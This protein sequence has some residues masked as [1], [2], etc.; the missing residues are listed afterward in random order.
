MSIVVTHGDD[1]ITQ[2]ELEGMAPEGFITGDI[3]LNGPDTD[4][5]RHFI[6][7]WASFATHGF[8]EHFQNVN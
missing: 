3:K 2:F 5:S 7:L 4:F 6:R 8:D 1:A